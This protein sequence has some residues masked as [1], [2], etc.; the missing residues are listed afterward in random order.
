MMYVGVKFFGVHRYEGDMITVN[1]LRRGDG[2]L[3]CMS[4]KANSVTP[5]HDA[6]QP[7]R[8]R[9]VLDALSHSS[10]CQ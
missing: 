3:G 9:T 6:L 8:L 5:Y 10:K 4:V 7:P 1:R 2:L